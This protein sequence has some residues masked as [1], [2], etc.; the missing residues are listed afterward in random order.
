M[1]RRFAV[2]ESAGRHAS[3]H[4]VRAMYTTTNLDLARKKAAKWTREFQREMRSVGGTSGGYVVVE[5]EASDRKGSPIGLGWEVDRA[6]RLCGGVFAR[7]MERQD[8][9]K[10]NHHG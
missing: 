3:G 4:V 7:S 9:E 5:C 1:E 2:V 10:R 6:P 8:A